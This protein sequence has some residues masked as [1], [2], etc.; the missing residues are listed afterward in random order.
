[1]DT[2]IESKSHNILRYMTSLVLLPRTWWHVVSRP[3]TLLRHVLTRPTNAG[4]EVYT[5]PALFAIAN[6]AAAIALCHLVQD[7][8]FLDR[9]D[10]RVL[11]DRF[12]FGF[13][14][15]LLGNVILLSCMALG[16][17]LRTGPSIRSA[18]VVLAY[19]SAAYI[20]G[21]LASAVFLNPAIWRHRI[22]EFMYTLDPSRLLA[23]PPLAWLGMLIA[24]VT[25]VFWLA[26]LAL[27][28]RVVK[29]C[30]LVGSV[31][32]VGVV[33]SLLVGMEIA[34][35]FALL[36]IRCGRLPHVVR[37]I[38]ALSVAGPSIA[39]Q[40][41]YRAAERLFRNVARQD[42][43]T[44]DQRYF[45]Q[46]L[47]TIASCAQ[48]EANQQ[49]LSRGRTGG[50]LP[51][52]FTARLARTRDE[53]H[54]FESVMQDVIEDA[55]VRSASDAPWFP[56][57]D[58][59]KRDLNALKDLRS[60][61][62]VAATGY[63]PPGVGCHIRITVRVKGAYFSLWPRAV[64]GP[65]G[66]GYW[67]SMRDLPSGGLVRMHECLQNPLDHDIEARPTQ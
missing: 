25:A 29:R 47:A 64:S 9:V 11:T 31:A 4:T 65:P 17:G 50:R 6:V 13:F 23:M 51:T 41:S 60:Q 5:P 52:Q 16:F 45:A 63:R 10:K 3:H 46:Q 61:S 19:G 62:V 59:W 53:M 58:L 39:E 54:L 8:S 1:M 7:P 44:A 32:R 66:V 26:F 57:P 24:C 67:L 2:W 48:S 56:K 34:I 21:C 49:V 20:P 55:S 15:W 28:M 12:A 27:G 35:W 37:S 38:E 36:L 22:A 14:A 18:F 42:T 33:V 40:D 43:F 30:S